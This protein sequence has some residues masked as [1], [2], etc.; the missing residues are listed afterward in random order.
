MS[1]KVGPI[2]G[3]TLREPSCW[4][5]KALLNITVGRVI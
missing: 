2:S 3:N 5:V 4:E 1:K